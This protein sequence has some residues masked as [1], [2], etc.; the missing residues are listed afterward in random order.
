[1]AAGG[2]CVVHACVHVFVCIVCECVHVCVY[3]S[4]C[5]HVC[6]CVP[7]FEGETTNEATDSSLSK[8]SFSKRPCGK[9]SKV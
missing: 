9:W 1:M 5:E 3:V 8:D 7:V 6:V 4:V 2:E